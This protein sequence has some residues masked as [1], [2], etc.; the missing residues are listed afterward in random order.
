MT[1]GDIERD[2][3]PDYRTTRRTEVSAKR[4]RSLSRRKRARSRDE[5]AAGHEAWRRYNS[6]SRSR[7]RGVTTRSILSTANLVR[8]KGFLET[9][10]RGYKTSLIKSH[11]DQVTV[12]LSELQQLNLELFRRKLVVHAFNARYE[13][14][15]YDLDESIRDFN[16][17]GN[18][19]PLPPPASNFLI[20]ASKHPSLA[21]LSVDLVHLF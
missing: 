14:E 1:S 2:A 21:S 13:I 4:L 12:H 19:Q 6:R 18:V 7:E 5:A 15:N 8:S 11:S 3:Y 10:R 20:P 17:Y 9:A 16:T